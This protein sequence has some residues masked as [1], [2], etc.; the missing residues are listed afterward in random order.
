MDEQSP[1]TSEPNVEIIKRGNISPEIM[2]TIWSNKAVKKFFLLFIIV[3]PKLPQN[4]SIFYKIS[5]QMYTNHKN[6]I[7]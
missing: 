2:V 5:N 4:K 7:I 3:Y 1:L 6:Y